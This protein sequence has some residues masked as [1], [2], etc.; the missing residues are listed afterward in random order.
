[1]VANQCL[2][3]F[4]VFFSLVGG[5]RHYFQCCARD[6]YLLFSLILLGGSLPQPLVVFSQA[7]ICTQLN[8]QGGPSED[9]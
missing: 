8:T 5:N 2:V 9:R 4:E 6:R 3:H 7:L 1:M